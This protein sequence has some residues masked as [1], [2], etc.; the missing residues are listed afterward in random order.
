MFERYYI[1]VV[2]VAVCGKKRKLAM[3]KI[4]VCLLLLVFSVCIK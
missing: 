2:N 3:C 4:Q 1:G